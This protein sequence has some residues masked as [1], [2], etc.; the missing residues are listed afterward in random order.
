MCRS[1]DICYAYVGLASPARRYH[2]QYT[3]KT[4]NKTHIRCLMYP[5]NR[6]TAEID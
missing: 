5:N 2:R 6:Y 1:K 4:E 3:V